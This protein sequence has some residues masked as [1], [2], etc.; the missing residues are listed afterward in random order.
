MHIY[1]CVVVF[2]FGK[3]TRPRP[4]PPRSRLRTPSGC[5]HVLTWSIASGWLRA[6]PRLHLHLQ[7]FDRHPNANCCCSVQ[8]CDPVHAPAMSVSHETEHA[9]AAA[10]PHAARDRSGADGAGVGAAVGYSSTPTPAIITF[11][12]RPLCAHRWS[13]RSMAEIRHC[14]RLRSLRPHHSLHHSSPM[15][16]CVPAS[17]HCCCTTRAANSRVRP[18]A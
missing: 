5:R 14:H 15:H 6:C 11:S 1:V 17:W 7:R 2:T 3:R 9:H 4:A 13:W 10:R 8:R 12:P 16:S 18:S